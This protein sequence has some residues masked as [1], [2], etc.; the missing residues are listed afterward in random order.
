MG[1]AGPTVAVESLPAALRARR[2]AALAQARRILAEQDV[3]FEAET[4]LASVL[5]SARQWDDYARLAE[6]AD[7]QVDR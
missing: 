3:V 6:A 4:R 2:D 7:R 1:A 5:Y